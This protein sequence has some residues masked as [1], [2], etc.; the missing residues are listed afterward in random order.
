MLAPSMSRSR[1]SQTTG[2]LKSTFLKAMTPPSASF[3][4][5]PCGSSATP[6]MWPG[7]RPDAPVGIPRAALGL[8][9]LHTYASSALRAA[10]ASSSSV[11]LAAS[12]LWASAAARAWAA[13]PGASAASPSDPVLYA[14]TDDRDAALLDLRYIQGGAVPDRRSR[15]PVPTTPFQG[16][17]G[18]PA[19]A[20]SE[21]A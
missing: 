15:C 17:S 5:G 16:D 19:T 3:H 1:P 6:R 13:L 7:R 10:S 12:A 20:T 18:G 14:T 2:R 4:L 8:R 11:A 9:A 21:L